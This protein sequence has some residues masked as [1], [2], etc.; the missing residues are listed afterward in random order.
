ML[1]L[2]RDFTIE[3]QLPRLIMNYN[4]CLSYSLSFY[5]T[6]IINSRISANHDTVEGVSANGKILIKEIVSLL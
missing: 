2:K 1:D 6:E 4:K 3:K 5:A